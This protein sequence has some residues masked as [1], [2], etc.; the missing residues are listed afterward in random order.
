MT[1]KLLMTVKGFLEQFREQHQQ[2]TEK[3][4]CFILGAG[5]SRT[6]K[7][8]TGGELAMTWLQQLHKE[9]DFEVKPLEAWATAENLGIEGFDL[10]HIASFYS[11]LYELRFDNSPESGYAFL[12]NVM[13]GKE[14]SFGYSVLA[15][16]CRRPSTRSSSRRISTTL[17]PTPFPF[18]PAPS[19]SSSAMTPWRSMRAWNSVVP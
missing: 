9:H 4:F 5:A 6:S 14:P 8:P 7:I 16:R 17:S 10:A 19:L 12:E 1:D 13:Q 15:Y 3:P 18:T 2:R 11:Q